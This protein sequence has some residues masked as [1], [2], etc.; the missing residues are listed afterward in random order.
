LYEIGHALKP[1]FPSIIEIDEKHAASMEDLGRDASRGGI[2]SSRHVRDT[3]RNRD[4]SD[5]ATPETSRSQF[6]D[7]TRPSSKIP[8]VHEIVQAC[9]RISN[10][11]S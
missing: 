10:E 7:P 3:A 6:L 9:S 1:Y 8:A 4:M 5:L 11:S 2:H